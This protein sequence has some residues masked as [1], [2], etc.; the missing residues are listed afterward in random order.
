MLFLTWEDNDTDLLGEVGGRIVLLLFLFYK[1][2]LSK[3]KTTQKFRRIQLWNKVFIFFSYFC[4]IL[5]SWGVLW[6]L[7]IQETCPAI[8][9]NAFDRFCLT[10]SKRL[11]GQS[12]TSL[13][14]VIYIYNILP[15]SLF[16]VQL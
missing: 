12:Y 11:K 2:R 4:N 10:P 15:S 14:N 16:P 6:L 9:S 3:L 7:Y 8:A 5:A 13:G 1:I